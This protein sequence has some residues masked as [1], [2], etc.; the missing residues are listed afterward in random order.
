MTENS[1][2][3]RFH[4]SPAEID[5]FLREHIAEDALLNFYRAVGD[6]VL[7]EALSHGR[8]H[9]GVMESRQCKHLYLSGMADVMDEIWDYRFYPVKLPQMDQHTQPFNPPK[10]RPEFHPEDSTRHSSHTRL[11]SPKEEVA[12]FLQEVPEGWNA[13]RDDD[14]DHIVTVA[15]TLPSLMEKLK[16]LP[17]GFRV[18]N[19]PT[20][21][22][23]GRGKVQQA[24]REASAE[25]PEPCYRG[26]THPAHKWLKGRRQAYCPGH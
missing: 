3:S 17:G 19:P 7:D 10:I 11:P 26:K 23:W 14:H 2:P 9:R 18:V 1:Q 6:E 24:Q 13:V 16:D 4:A 20:V 15:Y 12:I 21:S 5:A 22:D 25:N 8:A